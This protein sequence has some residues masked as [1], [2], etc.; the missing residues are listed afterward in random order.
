MAAEEL[1]DKLDKEDIYAIKTLGKLLG[2][3]DV[4]GQVSEILLVESLIEKQISKAECEK[5]KN[6]NR[7]SCSGRCAYGFSCGSAII[8]LVYTVW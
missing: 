4:K 7:K 6:S 5:Q 2:K 8:R 3:T 1:N